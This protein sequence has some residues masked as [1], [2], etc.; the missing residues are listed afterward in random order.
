MEAVRQLGAMGA[1]DFLWQMYQKESSVD[2]K[3]QIISAMQVAGNVARMSEL[4]RTEK[5][6]ELRRTAVRNLGIMGSKGAGDTLVEL[7]AS[8]KDPT[9][10]RTII[11]ALF[12][13]GNATA[14]VGL[15]RKEQDMTMKR[16]IVQRLSTMANNQV[17]KD[18]MLELLK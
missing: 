14:L 9:I 12:T 10:R 5:D 6:V 13:Q 2:V 8:E 18:Y 15:A 4:A 11:N 3:R 7:Y 17:A 1:N 16:E